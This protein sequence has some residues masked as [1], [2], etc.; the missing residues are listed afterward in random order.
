MYYREISINSILVGRIIMCL[1]MLN[2]EVGS[3]GDASNREVHS[4]TRTG[5][6]TCQMVMVHTSCIY[7]YSAL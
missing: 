5:S 4:A 6:L 7:I 1:S 2:Y 3:A